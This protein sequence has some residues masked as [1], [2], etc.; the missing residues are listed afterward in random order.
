MKNKN[1]TASA[2]PII[3]GEDVTMW[4]LPDGAVARL[5]RGRNNDVAFSPNGQYL[6]VGTSIGFWLYELPTLSPIALF[7]YSARDG[8]CCCLFSRQSLDSHL[9]FCRKPKGYGTFKAV[10]VSLR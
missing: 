4:A 8:Q 10:L 3:D 5:G 6:A 1:S 2:L 7:G 9:H